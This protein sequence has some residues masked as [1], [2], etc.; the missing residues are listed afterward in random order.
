MQVRSDRRYRFARPAQEVWEAAT[1]IDQYRTWWPW[2]RRFDATGFAPGAEWTCLV[3][4]PLPYAV[5]LTI[6]IE[7]VVAARRVLASVG[8]DVTGT[9]VLTLTDVDGGSEARL[10]SALAPARG[11]FRVLATVARPVVRRGHDWV[12]DSGARQ[13][14]HAGLPE[15][16]PD[17]VA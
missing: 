11:F 3:K 1:A 12:L 2:L 9:A 17:P 14:R 10:V 7:E 15:V 8:G 13:F 5:R 6:T 16:D 4:P